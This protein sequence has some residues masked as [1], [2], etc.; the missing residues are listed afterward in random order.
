MAFIKNVNHE[1]VFALAQ[2]VEV[3]AGQVASKPWHKTVLSA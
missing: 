3:Q 1:E 2:Q